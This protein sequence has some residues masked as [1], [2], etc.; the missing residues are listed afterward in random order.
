MCSYLYSETF[1]S[2]ETVVIVQPFRR[3]S[4]GFSRSNGNNEAS[5]FVYLFMMWHILLQIHRIIILIP[6]ARNRFKRYHF[7]NPASI[8]NS[9][10]SIIA[11]QT[12]N[13]PFIW[14][15]VTN[16]ISSFYLNVLQ[17]IHYPDFLDLI[18]SPWILW[19]SKLHTH[20]NSERKNCSNKTWSRIITLPY[21][22][23][24]I[25]MKMNLFG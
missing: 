13:W 12:F 16:L 11:F 25:I 17:N 2:G 4:T 10:K 23:Q 3:Q 14:N 5:V 20:S 6:R 21:K 15:H 24:V 7:G 19:Y 9:A 8:E 22:I 1:T 18:V